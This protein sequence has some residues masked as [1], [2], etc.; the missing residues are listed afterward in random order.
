M[1]DRQAALKERSLITMNIHDVKE[2]E[3]A[4]NECR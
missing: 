3:V 4:K 1:A 2:T